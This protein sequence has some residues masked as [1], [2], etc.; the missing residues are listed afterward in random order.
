MIKL[1]QAKA[2]D[3]PRI[4][5]LYEQLTE[6]KIEITT[7][8]AERIFAEIEVIPNHDYL[9]AEVDGTVAG[10]LYCQMVPNLSHAGRKWA[11]IENVVVDRQFRR[12]GIGRA[13]IEWALAR[14][15]QEGCYKVQLLSHKR[16]VEAHQFYRALG[17]EESALGFRKYF[18]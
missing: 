10:T 13:L 11:A 1:R 7:E 14:C 12:A 5:E 15:R 3:L 4:I 6:D 17:F 9:V 16:R 8:Y 18:E 2:S